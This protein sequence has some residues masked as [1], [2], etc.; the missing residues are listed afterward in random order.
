MQY[1]PRL[2][3]LRA[4]AIG[5]VFVEHFTYNEAIRAWKPGEMGVRLFFVLSGFLITSILLATRERNLGVVNAA[6]Q[7]YSRRVLRLTPALTSGIALAA[8]FGIANMRHDWWVHALY[9]TNFKVAIEQR[10]SGASHFWTLAVEEQFYLLWFTIVVLAPRN[11]LLPVV[12]ACLVIGPLYR[13]LLPTQAVEYLA[14]L[15]PGQ[16]DS[17]ATGALLACAQVRAGFAPV[18]RFFL[19]GWVLCGALIVMAVT[20][21]P[22]GAPESLRWVVAPMAMNAAAGCAVRR[23]LSRTDGDSHWLAAKPLC[24]VGRVSYGLYVYHY[25]IPFA[26][27]ALVPALGDMHGGLEK[28][29]R[30]VCWIIATFVV[31]EVSW[32]VI[33][34]PVLRLKNQAFA[35]PRRPALPDGPDAMEIGVPASDLQSPGI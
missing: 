29:L 35:P 31:A 24:H 3:G 28:S 6:A 1:Y 17:L 9:L 20:L 10:W 34:R 13:S 7:F 11:V 25:F 12:L 5:G 19:N 32:A 30:V 27:Y 23:G 4:I 22:I 26:G 33:E 18:D 15:L 16:V 8:A 2:D 14:V 21:A